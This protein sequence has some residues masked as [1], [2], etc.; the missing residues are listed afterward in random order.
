VNGGK[1]GKGRRRGKVSD[2]LARIKPGNP[3][4]SLPLKGFDTVGDS[5]PAL[6]TLHP[7]EG[8]WP[9]PTCVI[10]SAGFE[11]KHVLDGLQKMI[12]ADSAFGTEHT[13]NLVAAVGGT[14]KLRR[15][16]GHSQGVFR[17]WHGHAEGAAGLALA[18]FAVAGSH[19]YRFRRQYVT[20]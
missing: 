6:R 8:A 12:D 3:C 13:R 19:A 16:A 7:D 10:K 18:F 20:H 5:D 14:R 11:G 2:I 15:L 1:T 17:H 9:E 4:L